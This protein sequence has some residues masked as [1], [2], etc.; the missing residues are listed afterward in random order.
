[1]G[2]SK[3]V[4]E[5]RAGP[6]RG[7]QVLFEVPAVIVTFAI[8]LHTAANAIL[9]TFAN[10]PI[11]ETLA[12]VQYWYLPIVAF[13]GF[14]VAQY[15]GQHIA[16][17][18]VYQMLPNAVRPYVLAFVMGA[19]SLLS[20]GF[21]WFS[22]PE[23]QHAME[24][25]KTAGVS[26]VP[27]WPTYYLPVLAFAGLTVLFAVAAVRSVTRPAE[28]RLS[29]EAEEALHQESAAASGREDSA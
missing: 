20:L 5:G 4:A 27:S 6:A 8:M 28:G 25:H 15:R 9:R 11:P 29:A 12:I 7:L 10:E 1:M 24:I 21:T 17:D 3:S 18:L 26:D 14:I 2:A 16:T 13:L 19:C 23:A 22:W